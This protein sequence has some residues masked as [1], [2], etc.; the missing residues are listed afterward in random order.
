MKIDVI[1]KNS[2]YID[3]EGY[4]NR[5]CKSETIFEIDIEQR[6]EY[7]N[8]RHLEFILKINKDMQEAIE[9]ILKRDDL[10]ELDIQGDSYKQYLEIIKR[11][12]ETDEEFQERIELSLKTAKEKRHEEYLILKKEFEKEEV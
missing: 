11:T 7:S 10:E 6:Q 9:E 3:D 2:I 1:G 5:Y 8:K 12:K 4:F